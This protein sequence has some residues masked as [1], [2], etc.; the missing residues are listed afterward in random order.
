MTRSTRLRRERMLTPVSAHVRECWPTRGSST[1]AGLPTF[2]GP[3]HRGM[4]DFASGHIF[5]GGS[6]PSALRSPGLPRADEVGV[7]ARAIRHERDALHSADRHQI[8]LVAERSPVIDG[9]F[10]ELG[11]A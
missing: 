2:T 11:R 1:V 8:E 4:L 3:H 6:A 9:E 7:P 10:L 5:F